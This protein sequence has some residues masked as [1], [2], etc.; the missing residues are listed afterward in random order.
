M[1]STT[2]Q[3]WCPLLM[4]ILNTVGVVGILLGYGY[5]ILP[6]TALNLLINGILAASLDWNV[7]NKFWL[8]AAGGGWITEVIGVQTGLLYGDY[9]YGTGLG[10][11]LAGVPILLGVLWFITL[12]GFG[13]WSGILLNRLQMHLP[14][15]NLIRAALA[16]TLMTALDAFIEPVAIQAGWWAWANIHVP[17]TNY[18]SWWGVSF[19]FYLLPRSSYTSR[20]TGILVLIFTLFFILLNSFQWTA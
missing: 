12:T 1:N 4:L 16:A 2:F 7:R 9:Q 13:H 18:A 19:A 6:F 11:K 14:M 15:R 10:P 8:I 3:T 17:W 20:G 5:L